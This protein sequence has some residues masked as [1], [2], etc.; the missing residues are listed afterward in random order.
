MK[1]CITGASGFVGRALC[2]HLDSV[3]G[4]QI[5]EIYRNAL[6]DYADPDHSVVIQSID[7]DTDWSNALAGADAVIHMAARVHVMKDTCESPIDEYR[8]VNVDGTINLARQAIKFGVRRFIYLSSIKVNGEETYPGTPFRE[9]NPITPPLD[10]YALSKYEAEQGLLEIATNS[11]LEVVIIRPP[12]VY[13]PGVKANFLSALSWVYRKVPLP[14]G[15]VKNKRSL[16]SINNLLDFIKVCLKHPSAANEVF[17]V[18]DGLDV[19]TSQML[20]KMAVALNIRER[21]IP[22]PVSLLKVSTS[23]F[24]KQSVVDKL[25]SSLQ[26]DITKANQLLDWNPPQSMDEALRDTAFHFVQQQKNRR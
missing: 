14:L 25:T 13:G 17:F 26:V 12:L 1:I 3:S 7:K 15:A 6:P 10:P 21:L 23:L 24:G 5:I 18:S 8:K 16:V 2:L 22:V 20:K 9:N 11:K 4:I 19:S